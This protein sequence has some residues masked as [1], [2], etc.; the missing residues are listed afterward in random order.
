MANKRT[1]AYAYLRVSGP[2]QAT[3]KKHGFKRQRSV[4]DRYAKANRIGVVA[5]HRDVVTGTTMNRPALTDLFAA[6]VGN[7][8]RLVLVENR[9]RLFRDTLVGLLLLKEFKKLDVRVIEAESGSDLVVD[10]ETDPTAKLVNTILSALAEF[11]KTRI[12]MK[13]AKG[14]ADKSKEIGRRC[15]GRKPFGTT[16]DERGSVAI[17]RR[18]YRKPRGGRRLSLGKIAKALNEQGRASKSG[19]PWNASMVQGQLRRLG[20]MR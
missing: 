2:S 18:L 12:V 3:D 9:D 4:I 13:L 5:E 7:G 6:L 14:R 20:L 1:T 8:V 17:I 10:G 19:K 16:D 15:E 11:D